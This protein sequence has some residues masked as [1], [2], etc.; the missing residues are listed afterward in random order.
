MPTLALASEPTRATVSSHL[1]L[2]ASGS[3][4]SSLQ[5]RRPLWRRKDPAAPC[6]N[7]ALSP[8]LSWEGQRGRTS[9][10]HGRG[11][12]GRRSFGNLGPRGR[13]AKAQSFFA[14][15]AGR[16]DESEG[17]RRRF[18]TLIPASVSVGS[19]Y[20]VPSPPRFS[21]AS[22]RNRELSAS[23]ASRLAVRAAHWRLRLDR[24]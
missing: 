24:G 15:F 22:I 20:F 2:C 5:R 4:P 18:L 8:N 10:R 13:A 14:P 12:K 9:I 17:D 11:R 7:R 3:P 21:T 1:L 19:D 23:R 6:G 16:M